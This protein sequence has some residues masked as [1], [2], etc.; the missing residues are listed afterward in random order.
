MI[1]CAKKRVLVIDNS[2]F[3]ST[4][5]VLFASFEEIDTIIVARPIEDPILKRH[6]D[7][8]GVQVIVALP[9]QG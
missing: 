1:Q 9:E 2:K 6:L 3:A 5:M 4:G 8:I 7:E